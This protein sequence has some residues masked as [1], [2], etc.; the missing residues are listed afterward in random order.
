MDL[1]ESEIRTYQKQIEELK[2][3]V[4]KRDELNSRLEL[5]VDQLQ[6]LVE[7]AHV[8]NQD[9]NTAF[10]HLRQE[11]L[12]L[13]VHPTT[14]Q[15]D[16]HAVEAEDE[17]VEQIQRQY[18]NLVGESVNWVSDKDRLTRR[19]KFLERECERYHRDNTTLGKQVRRLLLTLEEERGMII[20]SAR[21]PECPNPRTA[22]DV[23]D[24]NLVTFESIEELQAQNQKLLS[25]VKELSKNEEEREL[26]I[27]NEDLRRLRAEQAELKNQLQTISKDRDRALA[28]LNTIFKE[29]DLFRI[30]LCKTRQVEH[31]TPEIFQRMVYIACS[32]GPSLSTGS[33][34]EST[35][36]KDEHI[37]SLQKMITKLELD[38]TRFR[39]ELETTKQRSEVELKL[40][41]ELLEKA[42]LEIMAERKHADALRLQNETYEKNIASLGSE[43]DDIRAK[44]QKLTCEVEFLAEKNKEISAELERE[45]I[46]AKNEIVSHLD[47]LQTQFNRTH[48]LQTKLDQYRERN[49]ELQDELA[50]AAAQVAKLRSDASMFQ[51][52]RNIERV[53]RLEL[54]RQSSKAHRLVDQLIK[55]RSRRDTRKK[56]M[57][58][59][60][61]SHEKPIRVKGVHN[62]KENQE[63]LKPTKRSS[64]I[65][66]EQPICI[67]DETHSAEENQSA[68]MSVDANEHH[69]AVQYQNQIVAE[70]QVLEMEQNSPDGQ[71]Q[72]VKLQ[73]DDQ[74][75]T[76]ICET[77]KE[78]QMPEIEEQMPET[79]EHT[80]ESEE[81][82]PGTNEPMLET[83]EPIL[84]KPEQVEEIQVDEQQN[85]CT[86]EAPQPEKQIILKRRTLD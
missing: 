53:E 13:Q 64:I 22:I 41:T 57:K 33:A 12:K 51:N 77:S 7:K 78:E 4:A 66:Q 39:D 45:R 85:S 6:N 46:S 82:M 36:D 86:D 52:L 24:N 3:Q 27:E 54:A 10:E 16:N 55:Q 44:A 30:L 35:Q 61:S 81:Q 84:E 20:K 50:K 43:F 40:K 69:D 49:I 26:Q 48:E 63:T 70:Q 74:P 38:V 75:Q 8:T 76:S 11:N 71:Q 19:V 47:K 60:R 37:A 58:F 42:H 56:F 73:I 32:A 68:E 29:R 14:N 15:I 2:T 67:E 31:L 79:Q 65:S 23:I 21:Q 62:L 17:A 34:I 9:L 5:R 83:N 1:Y 18:I 59:S 72:P 28:A 25:L 80:P